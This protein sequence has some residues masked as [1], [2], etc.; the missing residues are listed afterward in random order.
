MGKTYIVTPNYSIR[1]AA[2]PWKP[3]EANPDTLPVANSSR[4]GGLTVI[5][6]PP[7]SSDAEATIVSELDVEAELPEDRIT[8]PETTCLP[9]TEAAAPE[10]TIPNFSQPVFGVEASAQSAVLSPALFLGDILS[11]PLADE[12]VAINRKD[13][14][15]I[16]PEDL[17]EPD[18]KPG[19]RATR[20]DLLSGRFGIWTT[21]FA[22]LGLPVGAEVGVFLERNSNNIIS[23]SNLVTFEFD[24][25]QQ[26]VDESMKLASI[27]SYL[28]GYT[29]DEPPPPL[30]MVTG[31]KVAYGGSCEVETATKSGMSVGGQVPGDDM[32]KILDVS[33]HRKT[34][35]GFNNST[36]FV[37]AFRVR[38]V[39]YKRGKW[40]HT[41][42]KKGAS[43][44]DG[45]IV[46][47]ESEIEV[48]GL[49][50]N[51]IID[52]GLKE[53]FDY[54]AIQD[55]EMEWIVSGDL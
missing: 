46:L 29:A 7:D 8:R 17:L 10:S 3:L 45:S 5:N 34:G 24:A 23:T 14:K 35:D 38:K 50:N 43:M 37:L 26:F 1:A 42:S 31:L 27:S 55:G 21:F 22:T 41:L 32:K 28:K 40:E 11:D 33:R 52:H 25:T 51:Y 6:N 54:V 15:D 12:L 16:S 44:M 9:P 2:Y 39:L 36:P 20:G 47:Q 18:I 13:R 19:F 53:G 4:D 30:Y 49:E 48:D